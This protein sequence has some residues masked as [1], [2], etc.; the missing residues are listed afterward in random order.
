[1]D[2]LRPIRVVRSRAGSIP[3]NLW[4]LQ[5]F[6]LTP[7]K[8][9]YRIADRGAPKVLSVSLPKA[10]TH[11]LERTLCLHRRLYRKMLPTVWP[12]ALPKWDGLDGLL[13]TLAP[14]QV[15]VAHLDFD[16][17]YPDVIERAATKVL[18]LIR[19]PR[20]IVV[21][22][23]HF[24]HTRP[25]H[26]FHAAFA[27][28]EAV[29][30]RIRVAIEGDAATGLPSV[31]ERL[32]QYEGWLRGPALVVRFEDLIGPSG[33]GDADRQRASVQG[34]YRHLGI[35]AAPGTV[36]DVCDRLFSGDSPT[37]RRGSI[38][39]WE[40]QLDDAL[41]SRFHEIV[42]DRLATFGYRS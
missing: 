22:Q 15:V 7:S 31:A 27:K 28:Y 30:D 4:T 3:R 32:D 10:G 29:S 23:A 24:A 33:G 8:L 37:F 6:G 13:R 34:I 20:D 25:D 18:F 38:G 5:R 41:R 9:P 19:D 2:E 36:A 17:T 14:G 12:E 16:P 1:V 42:G 40:T 39:Q 26:P 11:L 35:D 21:S